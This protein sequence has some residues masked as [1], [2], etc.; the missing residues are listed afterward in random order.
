MLVEI[1][2]FQQ[3]KLQVHTVAILA[4]IACHQVL[5][6]PL[7]TVMRPVKSY[8]SGCR[9]FVKTYLFGLAKEIEELL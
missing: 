5:R 9:G 8:G 1:P 7:A 6:L 4:Q 3:G 2:D